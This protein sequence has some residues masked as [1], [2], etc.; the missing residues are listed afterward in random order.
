ML[1]YDS[2]MSTGELKLV[3]IIIAGVDGNA[4]EALIVLHGTTNLI[5][6][7]FDYRV[8]IRSRSTTAFGSM[9]L[10]ATY[11]SRRISWARVLCDYVDLQV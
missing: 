11:R 2:A 4:E 1:G 3:R 6:L 8:P 7:P 10:D 5:P 9:M